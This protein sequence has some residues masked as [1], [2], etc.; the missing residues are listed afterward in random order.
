MRNRP[1]IIALVVM[2][3]LALGLTAITMKNSG[4]SNSNSTD[5]NLVVVAPTPTP[6]TTQ[7][8]AIRDIPP[9]TLITSAMVREEET[10]TPAP[11][12]F[13]SVN[14]V[15]GKLSNADL[16]QAR[17]PLEVG[18]IIT[19]LQRVIPANFEVPA[20]LRAVAVFVD[21]NSTAAGLV[22]IGDRV[23]VISTNK[24]TFDKQDTERYEQV[25]V[26]S[27][28]YTEGRTVAQD[29]LVLAVDSSIQKPPPVPTPPP[30]AGAAPVAPPAPGT[31]ATPTPTPVAAKIRVVLATTPTV[32]ARLVAAQDS[33]SLHLT[34]RNPNSR[35]QQPVSDQRQSPGRVINIPKRQVNTG[36]SGNRGGGNNFPVPMI[37][38]P[39]VNPGG[40]GLTPAEVPTLTSANPSIPAAVDLAPLPSGS[41]VTVIRGTDKSRVTVPTG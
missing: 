5:P 32:A 29:L 19:P 15:I 6:K 12:A 39:A 26:G 2:G 30:V 1:L 24:Q 14:D 17:Q 25:Y 8:V 38:P 33:G 40:R 34:I 18:S 36:G 22:D 4:N 13:S 37:P 16:I 21:P 10:D 28:S 11:T 27:K 23:D 7:V 9:R 20:G 35:E 31:A 3:V 41:D